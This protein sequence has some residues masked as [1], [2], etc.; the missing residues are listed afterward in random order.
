MRDKP[1]NTCRGSRAQG[2]AQQCLAQQSLPSST[3][4]PGNPSTS[5]NL[6]RWHQLWTVKGFPRA[7][8][9]FGSCISSLA[10]Q[11]LHTGF[12]FSFFHSDSQKPA[13][14]SPSTAPQH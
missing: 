1:T 9:T 10:L 11:T 5:P 2:L 4:E 13:R 7:F 14:W 12:S 6:Q 3:R 8:G